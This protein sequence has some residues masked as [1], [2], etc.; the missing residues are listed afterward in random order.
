MGERL[1]FEVQLLQGRSLGWRYLTPRVRFCGHMEYDESSIASSLFGPAPRSIPREPLTQRRKLRPVPN[2]GSVSPDTLSTATAATN[3]AHLGDQAA[4]LH[5]CVFTAD[6]ARLYCNL[7][8]DA[9]TSTSL[10]S[11]HPQ[12]ASEVHRLVLTNRLALHARRDLPPLNDRIKL[13]R[14]TS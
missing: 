4:G 7:G 6:Y 1:S 2:Q 3:Y 8:V 13:F 12:C 9:G 5:S 14:A 11:E 10:S